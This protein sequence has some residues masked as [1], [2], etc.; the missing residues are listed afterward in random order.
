MPH[1]SKDN[2]TIIAND[3]PAPAGTPA[4]SSAQVIHGRLIP[5]Q[6]QILLYSPDEWE[7]F[8]NEWVHFAK[9]QTLIVDLGTSVFDP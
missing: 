2:T 9:E 6:Q 3:V 8:V 1:V 5:P 7:E 4:T